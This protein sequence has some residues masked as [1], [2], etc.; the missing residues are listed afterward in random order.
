MKRLI[1]AALVAGALVVA[2]AQPAAAHNVGH[3]VLPTGTCVEIGSFKSVFP[4]PDKTTPL[5]L[6]PETGPPLDEIGTSFAAWQGNTPIL[7]GPCG[8]S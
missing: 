2:L 8:V 6:I 1:K 3:V 4:G 7:P 5:D